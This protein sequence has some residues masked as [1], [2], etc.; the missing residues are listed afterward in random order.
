MHSIDRNFTKI[1]NDFEQF[2][3]VQNSRNGKTQELLGY[4]GRVDPQRCWLTNTRRVLDPHYA[5]AETLWYLGGTMNVIP[6]LPYAP[7][8]SKFTNHGYAHGAY[9]P[10]MIDQLNTVAQ[11]LDKDKDS[12]QAIVQL[13]DKNDLD[14]KRGDLPCTL[15]MQFM[16]REESLV[17]I[18]TMRSN[19]LW[20]GYPYDVFA[21]CTIGHIMAVMLDMPL[22]RYQHQAGSMHLYEKHWEPAAQSKDAPCDESH[23]RLWENLDGEDNFAQAMTFGLMYMNDL[24]AHEYDTAR[25]HSVNHHCGTILTDLVFTAVSKFQPKYAEHIRSPI[26]RKAVELY[27]HHR[28]HR[29]IGQDNVVQ[30]ADPAS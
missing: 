18:V 5:C 13:W 26:L 16:V 19:D 6:L 24:A 17:Q 3:S 28:G 14:R 15:S 29:S 30:D 10:R 8:Y 12:R 20:L 27:A 7:Q 21:F 9:G 4:A 2:G 23:A 1:L 22:L 25:M 11:L